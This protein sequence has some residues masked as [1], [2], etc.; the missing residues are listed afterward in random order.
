VIGFAGRLV[1]LKGGDLL[2]RALPL[3]PKYCEVAMIGE[4]ERKRDWMRLA[5]ELGIADRV[6]W[7]PSVLHEQMPSVLQRLD[8]LVLPSRTGR[9]WK[10]QFG[11]VLIEAMACGVVV[12]GSTSGEIPL[13]I[14]DAGEIFPEG[15]IRALATVLGS[16]A[17]NQAR[18]EVLAQKGLAKIHSKFCIEAVVPLYKSFFKSLAESVP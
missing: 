10:E 8:I 17:S 16:L 2:L 6:H 15:D 13:V 18:R 14:E 5:Q 1:D 11:R 4:G 9:L 12:V 7:E 3:L